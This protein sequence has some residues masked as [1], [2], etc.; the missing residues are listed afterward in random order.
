MAHI[1]THTILQ[2][3]AR[4]QDVGGGADIDHALRSGR[5]RLRLSILVLF[6]AAT[7]AVA[8]VAAVAFDAHYMVQTMIWRNVPIAT[9]L[10]K[11]SDRGSFDK[12]SI[13][14]SGTTV[15][16]SGR[17]KKDISRVF[18]LVDPKPGGGYWVRVADVFNQQWHAD[19]QTETGIPRPFTITAYYGRSGG[20][21]SQGAE[22]T[23]TLPADQ[24]VACAELFG[25]DCFTDPSFGQPSVYISDER[26]L[27]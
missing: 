3:I 12:V 19:V 17:A 15:T 2:E 22:Q 8:L 16:V 20:G 6:A 21:K 23:P 27:D 4:R 11:V 10:V 7:V 13:N 5:R 14:D 1:D 9:D 18:V 26:L 25:T 24:I